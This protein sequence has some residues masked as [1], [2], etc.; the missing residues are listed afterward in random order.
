MD[1]KKPQAL[2]YSE[3]QQV[4]LLEKNIKKMKKYKRIGGDWK[5]RY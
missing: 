2:V 4:A 3:K 1:F 5:T